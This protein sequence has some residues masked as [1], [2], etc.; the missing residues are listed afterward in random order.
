M[1]K[2][3]NG[4]PRIARPNQRRNPLLRV[5]LLRRNPAN[6]AAVE[7][8]CRDAPSTCHASAGQDRNQARLR[9]ARSNWDLLMRLRPEIS[10][11]AAR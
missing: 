9:I 8:G 2:R 3:A 10:I 6:W 1:T 4:E 7:A 5:K 11:L